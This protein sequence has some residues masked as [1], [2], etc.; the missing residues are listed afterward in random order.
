MKDQFENVDMD[1]IVFLKEINLYKRKYTCKHD[2][3]HTKYLLKKLP[4]K[5]LKYWNSCT[6]IQRGKYKHTMNVIP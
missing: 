3:Y 2:Q 4:K 6:T 5:I 1:N